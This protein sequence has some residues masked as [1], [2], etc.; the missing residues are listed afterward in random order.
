MDKEQQEAIVTFVLIAYQEVYDIHVSLGS[1]LCQ[2]DSRWK[3]IVYHDGPNETMRATVE[4]IQ[5]PRITYVEE[6]KNTGTWGVYN[7]IRSL[8]MV[9]TE[10]MV[11][12]TVQEYW[13]P[14]VVTAIETNRDADIVLWNVAHHHFGYQTLDSQL[15]VKRI[16]W[17]N[18]AIKT[19]IARQVGINHPKDFCAD[20]LFIQDC[21]ASGLIKKGIKIPRVLSIKN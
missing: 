1:L 12:G 20:G 10:W 18:F 5:D 4:G 19:E 16:D 7:R 17:S 2:K 11:Q 21:V 8:D 15:A 3:A 6:E 9:N 13:C 14:V